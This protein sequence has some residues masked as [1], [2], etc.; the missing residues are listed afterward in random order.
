[1]ASDP[2]R[3]LEFRLRAAVASDPGGF[4]PLVTDRLMPEMT[5]IQLAAAIHCRRMRS[6]LVS[7]ISRLGRQAITLPVAFWMLILP[8]LNTP[9]AA[10][11]PVDV[12]SFNI[13]TSMGEDGHNSWPHRKELVA[14]TILLHGP[15]IV[16]LQEVL[17]DQIE[18]L[19]SAL[20]DYRW[21]GTDRGLN[22]GVGLSEATPIFYRHAELT[23]VESGTFWLSDTPDG[24]GRGGRP[25][26]IVTWARFHH[27][28]TGL[29]LHVYNTHF[30]LRRDQRQVAAAEQIAA[31]LVE[32]P[33]A[34]PRIVLGDFNAVAEESDPWKSLV[35]AGLVDTWVEA[36]ER[37]G[38]PVTWSGF[39]PPNLRANERID[40]ILVGGPVQV[41][42]A[43]T[44]L[45]HREGRYPSDHYPV[46]A[47]IEFAVE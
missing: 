33:P 14:E 25:A 16:G 37:I 32:L 44:V 23:P 7:R 27:I 20:A 5:E 10:Q 34:T 30:G 26:R 2:G 3:P 17:S 45:H 47:R 38:P 42:R 18:Y 31:R 15:M 4:D 12:M 41:R 21:L 1:V 11:L 13:R 46:F 8:G 6:A 22:G 39:G 40:W 35:A 19:E 29:E 24:P 43:E 9:L 28:E 36:E